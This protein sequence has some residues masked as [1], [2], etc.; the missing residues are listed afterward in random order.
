MHPRALRALMR[1]HQLTVS[2]IAA[3]TGRS[4][5]A[6]KSWFKPTTGTSSRQMPKSAARLLR[7]ELARSRATV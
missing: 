4:H 6:V 7:L 1:R 3:M 2:D 5:W